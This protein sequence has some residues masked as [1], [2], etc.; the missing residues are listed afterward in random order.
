MPPL[1]VT[2]VNRGKKMGD[3]PAE[4]NTQYL[5]RFRTNMQYR[6]ACIRPAHSGGVKSYLVDE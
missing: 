6:Q 1:R 5:P 3:M 4:T 2:Q